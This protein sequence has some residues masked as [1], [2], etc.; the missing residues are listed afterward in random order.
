MER[1][2]RLMRVSGKKRSVRRK[3]CRFTFVERFHKG[4][5]SPR[6]LPPASR[7]GLLNIVSQAKR[8]RSSSA[9]TQ[10]DRFDIAIGSTFLL[11]DERIK[12]P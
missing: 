5:N 12:S 8:I 10:N 4:T 1:S 11:S 6:S 9:A 7:I 3:T 2:L